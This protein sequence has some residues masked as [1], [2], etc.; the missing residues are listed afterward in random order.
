M[1]L[2]ISSV[3]EEHTFDTDLVV[4][5]THEEAL[6]IVK[7]HCPTKDWS[8]QKLTWFLHKKGLKFRTFR[9]WYDE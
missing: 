9:R 7:E 3:L 2:P 1:A 4:G 5:K 8:D 6:E